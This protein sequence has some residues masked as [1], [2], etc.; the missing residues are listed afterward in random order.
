MLWKKNQT[1]FAPASAALF[2]KNRA[3]AQLPADGEPEIP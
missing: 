3:N 1:M 2:L